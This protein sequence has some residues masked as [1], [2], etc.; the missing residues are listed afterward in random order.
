MT[1][2]ALGAGQMPKRDGAHG[3]SVRGEG[4][5]GP[6]ASMG[7]GGVPGLWALPRLLQ[8]GGHFRSVGPPTAPPGEGC[9]LATLPPMHEAWGG[10]LPGIVRP[11]VLCS[12]GQGALMGMGTH[13]RVATVASSLLHV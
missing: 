7:G 9:P 5:P 1:A 12:E 4:P 13:V 6:A 3:P 2:Q 8:G 11:P 10:R